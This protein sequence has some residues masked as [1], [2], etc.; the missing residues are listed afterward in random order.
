MQERLQ[1]KVRSVKLKLKDE[2][3]WRDEKMEELERELSLC[4][5]ALT[6]EKEFNMNVM[7]ENDKLLIER[8]R[9]VQEL[10]EELNN[11][12][13]H[14]HFA[15]QNRTDLLEIENRTLQNRVVDLS[16][17]IMSMERSLRTIKSLRA[18]E[19]LK[20]TC[21]LQKILTQLPAQ[22]SSL[23]LPDVTCETCSF[24][25]GAETWSPPLWFSSTW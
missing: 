13:K 17:Q 10:N 23:K 21:D 24:L 12:K 8:R 14:V 2:M 11:N 15:L 18:A 20:N 3:K 19:E 16:N 22:T 5:H 1:L 6:M 25:S 4:S 9:L 7:M